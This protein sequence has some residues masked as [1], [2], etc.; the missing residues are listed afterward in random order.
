MA[1]LHRVAAYMPKL[2]WD[3]RKWPT[4]KKQKTF[5]YLVRMP[6]GRLSLD[7]GQ[8][9]QTGRR[10]WTRSRSHWITYPIWPGNA[11][12]SPGGAVRCCW[13]EG[14]LEYPGEPAPIMTPPLD[15]K[16]Q[17]WMDGWT[18]DLFM[19][20]TIF[21]QQNRHTEELASHCIFVGCSL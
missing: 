10:Q 19:T 12:G 9:E 11:S 5:R 8:T 20:K 21:H 14:C 15:H 13:G 1:F 3:I 2:G 7:V 6:R 17:Q 18:M 4:L 16:R